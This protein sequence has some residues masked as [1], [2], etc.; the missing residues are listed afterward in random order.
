MTTTTTTM[1][2]LVSRREASLID[3]S[4]EGQG[5]AREGGLWGRDESGS[6]AI[7]RGVEACLRCDNWGSRPWT[8]NQCSVVV[9][10]RKESTHARERERGERETRGRD[11]RRVRRL[12]W[13]GLALSACESSRRVR[14]LPSRRIRLKGSRLAYIQLRIARLYFSDGTWNRTLGYVCARSRKSTCFSG[15]NKKIRWN[16]QICY[17]I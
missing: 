7:V 12:P 16:T 4:G 9:V 1:E 15:R 13:K 5:D 14:R 8:C 17:G 11:I 3:R 2:R 10:P 6:K